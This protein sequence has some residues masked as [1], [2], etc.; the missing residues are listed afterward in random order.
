MSKPSTIPAPTNEKDSLNIQE[1]EELFALVFV[2][3][4]IDAKLIVKLLL[5]S[6]WYIHKDTGLMFQALCHNQ[7]FQNQQGRE[8]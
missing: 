3:N 2:H 5:S 4:I 8:P 7:F 6:T 1:A